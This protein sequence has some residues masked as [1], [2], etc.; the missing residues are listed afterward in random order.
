[1]TPS[2]GQGQS[3]NIA[4]AIADV[5]ER[6]AVLV[7]EEIELA[8]A[9]VSEKVSRLVR[10]AVVGVAAGIFVVV[11]LLFLMHGLAWLLYDI[12]LFGNN[13]SIGYFVIAGLMLVLAAVAGFLAARWIKSSSSLTP[14]LAIDEAKKIRETVGGEVDEGVTV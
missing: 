8:K 2:N 3:Q 7:R 14:E 1:M 10:G 5:S 9:E 12:G 13:V 11:G 4:T 6:A